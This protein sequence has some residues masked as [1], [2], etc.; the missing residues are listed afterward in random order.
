MKDLDLRLV[1]EGIRDP[2]GTDD[3]FCMLG[4]WVRLAEVLIVVVHIDVRVPQQAGKAVWEGGDRLSA[5]D[6]IGHLAAVHEFVIVWGVRKIGTEL[7]FLLDPSYLAACRA[8]LRRQVFGLNRNDRV[9]R[10]I[11]MGVLGGVAANFPL[12]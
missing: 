12:A 9:R 2:H 6:V 4:G 1:V 10:L 8:H 3:A 5:A 7:G 11:C